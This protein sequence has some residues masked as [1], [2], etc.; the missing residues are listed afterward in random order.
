MSQT[1]VFTGGGSAGH[2]T[3]NLVLISKCAEENWNIHYIG[4]EQGIER[5]LVQR[6][7]A[8]NYHPISTGKLRRYFSWDNVK[9]V[10]R[11]VK[12]V[13][14]SYRL[15]RQ[16]K[17][18]VVFSMGGFVSVPVVLGAK[19]C[20]IPII[21]HEPDLNMGLA[22]RIALPLANQM[23]TTFPETAEA[24]S[25][26]YALYTGPIIR[27]EIRSGNT[28]QG[29]KLCGF[30]AD[31]PV[32]LIMGGSQGAQRINQMVRSTLSELTKSF[33]IVH[34]CG[35]GKMD[36]TASI[37]GYRTFEFVGDELPNLIAMA[38]IVVSRAGSNSMMEL[39]TLHKPMLLIPHAYGGSVKGQVVNAQY[40]H[41]KGYASLLL[42][43]DMT[44]QA[45]MEAMMELYQNRRTYAKA[46]RL[47]Q[48]GEGANQI[49]ACIREISGL[50][51][52]AI[53]K[54]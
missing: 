21:I 50:W 3:G 8:V 28:L 23:C 14:Q 41:K 35:K 27:P 16:I 2:V 18:D 30:T 26:R 51:N 38:D 53:H 48:D 19:L 31:R 29:L 33:Q 36:E 17:P 15:M 47:H 39:L 44:E 12:G 25:S 13:F 43:H 45:F 7:E 4:S 1:I 40:F 22:N 34:I 10:F 5:E 49:M 11:V 46:M 6:S 42:E 52:R 37:Q 32:V 54:A 20:R 9:D 24:K